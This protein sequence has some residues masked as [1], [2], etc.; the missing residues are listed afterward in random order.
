MKLIFITST[1]AIGLLFNGHVSIGQSNLGCDL[2]CVTN[3]TLNTTEELWYVDIVFEG[4]ETD[5]INYAYVTQR[6]SGRVWIR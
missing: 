2:F 4:V 1:L 3:I 6:N 5:F